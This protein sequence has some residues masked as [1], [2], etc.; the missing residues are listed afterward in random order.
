MIY[1]LLSFDSIGDSIVQALRTLMASIGALLYSLI[2]Y[3]YT[4]FIYVGKAEILENDF[5]QTI[6]RKVGLI[7]GLFMV[8][9]LTFSLV[10]YIYYIHCLIY[11]RTSCRPIRRW[12]STVRCERFNSEDMSAIDLSSKRLIV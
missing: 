8:F 2:D 10:R 7:L 4:V 5:I 11:S 3:L 1:N 9:K 12:F 6:Y